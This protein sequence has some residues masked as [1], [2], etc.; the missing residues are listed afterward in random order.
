MGRLSAGLLA[1]LVLCGPAWAPAWAQMGATS[2]VDADGIVGGYMLRATGWSETH[3]IAAGVPGG[4]DRQVANDFNLPRISAPAGAHAAAFNAA[5]AAAAAALW[6]AAGAP[7][8]SLARGAD[9][10]NSLDFTLRPDCPRPLL[11]VALRLDGTDRDG[12]HHVIARDFDW[13][14]DRDRLLRASDL[15]ATQRRAWRGVLSRAAVVALRAQ[16]DPAFVPRA[17]TGASGR[18]GRGVRQAAFEA[19]V[20]DPRSWLPGADGLEIGFGSGTIANCEGAV[21]V[22]VPWRELRDILRPDGIL[23][24][25]LVAGGPAP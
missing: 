22:V 11:C 4:E 8:W 1:L 15:F 25:L 13:L 2:A 21:S 19:L 16:V 20:A 24:G 23:R 6:T 12:R 3:Q 18:A 5:I 7:A 14:A 9:A 10:S 17:G